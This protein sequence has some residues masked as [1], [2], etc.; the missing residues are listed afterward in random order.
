MPKKNGKPTVAEKRAAGT[1][2]AARNQAAKKAQTHTGNVGK[3]ASTSSPRPGSVAAN[4]AAGTNKAAQNQAAKSAS[5][6]SP[7]PGSVAA[8][9][10]AGTNKAAQ[11][12]AAKAAGTHTGNVGKNPSSSTS[13]RRQ[14]NLDLMNQ[15]VSNASDYNFG[16]YKGGEVNQGELKAMRRA[17]HSRADIRSAA[18]ASGMAISDKAQ[19]RFNR[20]D[21]RAAAKQKA[22]V[23]VQDPVKQPVQENSNAN[24]EQ[25][26]NTIP[27]HKPT[28]PTAEV[29]IN[30][31]VA[32]KPTQDISVPPRTNT[33]VEQSQD[34]QVTQDNDINS[35]VNG[36]NNNVNISQDNSV[37]QYGGVNKSFVYNGGSNGNN[38]MDTPVSAG[39]MGGYF[40]DEDSPGKSASF[41]DRYQ[42][43]NRDYQK[44]F[45]NSNFAQQAITKASQNT[46]TDVN[47][48]D[49]RINDRA[50]L[51]RARS[52]SMA[53][54]IFGDMF[55]YSPE[56]FEPAKYD[57]DKDSK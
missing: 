50:K 53:G 3:S 41:V 44:Q 21:A 9:R 36:D 2:N 17:G 43:M 11:N 23:I 30:K 28:L 35:S 22:Q 1:N 48:L 34:Q 56:E 46:A 10:A 5:T 27:V 52:T 37:R 33:E 47:A 57:Y 15:D 38:Y 18:E 16:A 14:A 20:W 40:H 39:T 55:N 54:D 31:P 45:S 6:S 4:R 13:T 32:V 49:Q 8:N 25:E 42:T 29:I 51:S 24:V 7:R 19:N 12:Q 26:P